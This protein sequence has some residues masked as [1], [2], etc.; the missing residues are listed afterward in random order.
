MIIRI[1]SQ[2]FD[3]I[4]DYFACICGAIL[5]FLMLGICIN[6]S[7]R[8]IGHTIPGMEEVCEYTLLWMTFLGTTWVLKRDKHIKIDIVFN[9]LNPRQ[10]DIATIIFSIISAIIFFNIGY[11]GTISCIEYIQRNVWMPQVLSLPKGV[12]WSVVPLGSFL[13]TLQ[14][15]RIIYQRCLHLIRGVTSWNGIMH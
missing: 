6:V 11:Y 12:V 5:I 8:L 14:F 13:L 7:M 10:Q 9:Y 3:R 4:I 15:I 2:V 1:L